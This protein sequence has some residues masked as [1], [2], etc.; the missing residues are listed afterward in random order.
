MRTSISAVVI[1][2][3][4][5][6]ASLALAAPSITSLSPT[7]G[8]VGAS[9]T[10]TGS[11]FGST[12]GSSTVK[13]N[14]TTATT[15]STWSATSIV[16]VVPS[17]A[18]TGNV[19]V[20][21]SG[22]ASNGKSFTVVAAPSITSLSPT[23]GAVG[24]SITVTGTNF[25]STQGSSTIKFNGTS[26]TPTSWS[27]TQIQAPVPSG[28]TTG[29]VVV[30]ASG[31][32]S[33]GKNFTVLPTPT[34]TNLSPNSG[35]V[36]DSI[37]I[38]GTN[39]GAT[40]GTSTVKFNGTAATPTTW[41]N[42]SIVTS[43]PTG[44]TTGNVV[45]TVSGVSSAGAAFTVVAQPT[46]T[47][48]SP[49]SAAVGALVT[50]NGTN[51]QP[52]QSGSTV[53]FNG[54]TATPT[55]WSSTQIKAPV[56][57]GATTGNVVVTVFGLASNGS[58]FTV[59][60]TPAITSLSQTI[61]AVGM[62][63]TINGVNFGS[64][65]GSSTVK[66]NGTTATASAWSASQIT[67]TVPTGATSGNV[68]VHT[69]G[70]DTNGIGFTVSTVNSISLTPANL[71]IPINSVQ[72]F[73]AT[74]TYANNSTQALTGNN[75]TWG[76]S[77][78]SIATLDV[79]GI[80]TT[81]AQGQ[82]T[83]QATLG[84]VSASTTLTVGGPSFQPVGNLNDP[85]FGH[86]ATLLQNGKVLIVGGGNVCCTLSSAELYDPVTRSFTR[87]GYLNTPRQYHVAT[88][89]SSGKVLITG[90]EQY[91]PN[92]CSEGVPTQ[93]IYDPSSGI[94]TQ[95]SGQRSK[96]PLLTIVFRILPEG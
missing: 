58:S 50:I 26:V 21:V 17:S 20:T 67:V 7:S 94:F 37:T 47:S 42:T 43:V 73:V 2:A 24:T 1:S 96:H 63:V 19:V 33:N 51:F 82:T 77:S 18:T 13:F 78:T 65:Q 53:T 49:T 40:Q 83:I 59:K 30:H 61:G 9:V 86:T 66:F 62:A 64:S 93:E 10:I 87:T 79:N 88:L 28:A 57:A 60:P 27:A 6:S 54:A 23:S 29:N 38:T 81:L 15:I 8:A 90:G 14:G 56:P 69:S 85:R 72:R 16:A 75:V 25:G 4:I 76:S 70:V 46:I 74:A 45:V 80:A 39:F 11:N 44:A 12:Q 52:T 36:G 22:V 71:S 89:L 34:I 32:D 5:F 55:T 68:V 92:C 91:I 35:M 31:V 84:S 3:L 41:S 95:L 48:L